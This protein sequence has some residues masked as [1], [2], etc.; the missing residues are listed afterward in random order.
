MIVPGSGTRTVDFKTRKKTAK[1]QNGTKQPILKTGQHSRL[2]KR[3]N[4]ANFQSGTKNKI[5][6]KQQR[7]QS[8]VNHKNKKN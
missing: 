5:L 4:A 3:D 8:K 2:L 1:F 7:S 6:E